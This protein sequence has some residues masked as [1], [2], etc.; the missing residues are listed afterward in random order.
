[1]SERRVA[2]ERLGLAF[3]VLF[4]TGQVGAL[5]C[6]AAGAREV[7]EAQALV[8]GVA[9]L[10]LLALAWFVRPTPGFRRVRALHVAW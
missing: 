9:W 6:G 3:V 2:L 7:V 5:V 4:G 10:A 8:T 1:V